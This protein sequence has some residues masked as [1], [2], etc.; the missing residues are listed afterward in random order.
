MLNAIISELTYKLKGSL[1]TDIFLPFNSETD[2][3]YGQE[4]LLL[5]EHKKV[6]KEEKKY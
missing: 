5:K 6:R 3:T 1:A 2:T 4:N